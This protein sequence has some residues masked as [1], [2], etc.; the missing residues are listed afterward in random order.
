MSEQ[1]MAALNGRKIPKSDKVFGIN[2]MA[3]DMVKEKGKDAVVNATIGALMDDDGGLIVLSSVDRVFRSLAPRE[4]AQYAPIGGT[5]EFKAAAIKAALGDYEIDRHIRAVATMGGTGGIKNAVSNYSSPG[6]SVLTTDWRWGPY[7]QITAEMGRGLET[8]PLF[9]EDRGFNAHAFEMKVKD[10]LERQSRLIIILNTPAHNP[11]GYSLT[12]EDWNAIKACLEETS[13]D[14]R[15]ILYADVAYI[16]FAGDE[17]A[18]RSFL[19]ILASM[20]QN[21]LPIIGYSMSKTF[22]I[23]GMRCGAMICLA[24]TAEIADEFQHCCEFSCRASWSNP[25]RAAQSMISRI[26]ADK[27]LYEQVVAERGVI[28]D[29]LLARGRA[30]D[31]AARECGLETVPFSAGFFVSVP[32][33]DPEALAARLREEGIFLIPLA[34]GVR[35]SVASI[36]EKIC[37]GLP[38]RILA[39][40]QAIGE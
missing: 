29:M 39:A 11:T 25:V 33:R 23:Y 5:P 27:A 22:T 9:T 21:V 38:A 40:R 18:V 32:S 13:P 31:S 26:F 34:M 7:N 12:D 10:M 16:D 36:P 17:Q 30:F 6:E 8:F 20:P 4:Y 37:A 24:P 2:Q 19:P 15:I 28:R 3:N 1:L 35:V 14:K